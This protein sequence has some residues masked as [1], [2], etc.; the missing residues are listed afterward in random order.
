[1]DAMAERAK[2]DRPSIEAYASLHASSVLKLAS[3]LTGDL[4]AAEDAAAAALA[5]GWRAAPDDDGRAAIAALVRRR[6]A[7]R[8][9]WWSR[10]GGLH[11]Q[12]AGAMAATAVDGSDRLSYGLSQLTEHERAAVTLRG[13]LGTTTTEIA[14]LLGRSPSEV[15]RDLDTADGIVAQ[16]DP[17]RSLAQRDVEAELADFFRAQDA[18]AEARPTTRVEQRAAEL[19]RLRR[20]RT[21][22]ATAAVAAS[23]AVGAVGIATVGFG[24]SPSGREASGNAPKDRLESTV[25]PMASALPVIGAHRKLVGFRSVGVVVPRSW[26]QVSAPCAAIKH[27]AVV[28]PSG[29]AHAGP[30]SGGDVP[31]GLS[32]VAFIVDIAGEPEVE[33]EFGPRRARAGAFI[34]AKPRHRGGRYVAYTAAP[35]LGF[36]LSITPSSLP[37]LHRI[38]DSITPLPDGYTTVPDCIGLESGTVDALLEARGLMPQLLFDHSAIGLPLV[39]AQQSQSVGTVVPVQT[40]IT[41]GLLPR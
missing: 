39:V 27:N 40:R 33:G 17:A 6:V 22:L 34:I 30:C 1:M 26:R 37:T 24:G 32:A 11:L 23:V 2:T 38:I 12:E 25:A 41:V 29:H 10:E 19:H 36:G 18:D 4:Q 28:F 31:R 16:S 7:A 20:L 13:S 3:L 14:A 15:A 9:Q 35:D 8:S 5:R 21:R